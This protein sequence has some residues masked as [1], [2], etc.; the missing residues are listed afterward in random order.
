MEVGIATN[1]KGLLE[2]T[3]GAVKIL[4]CH[5]LELQMKRT[6]DC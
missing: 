3:V 2:V 1:V 4:T 5:R 6:W